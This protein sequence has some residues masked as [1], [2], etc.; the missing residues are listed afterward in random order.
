MFTYPLTNIPTRDFTSFDYALYRVRQIARDTKENP[1]YSLSDEEWG[2]ILQD[3]KA[4]NTY[5]V[6]KA[7]H[8]AIS[9]NPDRLQ[10]ISEESGS[11][12]YTDLEQV[13]REL[14]AS[15]R[16]LN[17]TLGVAVVGSGWTSYPTYVRW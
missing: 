6:F 8:R 16:E 17:R 7:V 11:Y 5:Q 2:E 14:L 4:G 9:T 12:T 10:A 3:T 1:P 15:Q 13:K